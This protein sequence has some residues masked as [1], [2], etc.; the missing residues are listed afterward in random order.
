MFA[1]AARRRRRRPY[2]LSEEWGPGHHLPSLFRQNYWTHVYTRWVVPIEENRSRIFYFH[3]AKP[4]NWLGRVYERLHFRFIH[5]WLVNQNFSEQ[6]AK[7][8][9]EAYHDTPEYLSMSDQQVIMW[10]KFL[11]SARG[12]EDSRE[13]SEIRQILAA[14]SNGNENSNGNGNAYGGDPADREVASPQAR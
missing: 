9:V 1:W 13:A 7:G 11:L 5:N 2:K 10:R 12:M 3:S 6:D 8:A 4:A 14:N